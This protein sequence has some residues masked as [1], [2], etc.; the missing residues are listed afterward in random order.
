MLQPT[1]DRAR[2]RDRLVPPMP[3]DRLWGWLGPLLVTAVAGVL[4]F[5]D[6]CNLDS[7][8][9]I[10]TLDEGIVEEDGSVRLFGRLAG[11]T[12]RGCSLSVE[13]AWE[14]RG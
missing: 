11:A 14:K 7:T 12:P 3:T 8:L 5:W 2:V 9:G 10:E 1:V 13:E 4:R 6:L